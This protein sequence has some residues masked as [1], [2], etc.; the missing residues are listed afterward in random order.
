MGYFFRRERLLFIFCC[1]LLLV[2]SVACANQTS[3]AA[4]AVSTQTTVSGQ[5]TPA[6]ATSPA[7]NAS[8]PAS[9]KGRAAIMPAIPLGR[10]Q[11]IVYYRN[12]NG[13]ATLRE[14]DVQD[15]TSSIIASI[16]G[17]TIDSAQ[18]A[19]NG[20]WVLMVVQKNGVQALQL[21][22]VDGQDLQ[23]L[24]CAS[25]GQKV[26][27]QWSP[28]HQ[29]ILFSQNS[30]HEAKLLLLNVMSGV[31]QVEFSN[32]AYGQLKPLT[33]LDN[34][35]VYIGLVSSGLLYQP[36]NLIVLDT[37]KGANQQAS[38]LKTI[39]GSG[40]SPWSF[41]CGVDGRTA[42]FVTS[43]EPPRAGALQ[44]VIYAQSALSSGF[45]NA[46]FTSHS[47]YITAVRVV[48][49]KTLMFFAEDPEHTH[50]SANG[51]YT[52]G[53]DGHGLKQVVSAQ[54]PTLWPFN[55][56][57]QYT[58]SSFSRNGVYYVDGLSYGSFSGGSLTAYGS[59]QPDDTLVG[60]TT[61]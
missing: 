45:T 46:I 6:G 57:S 59:A 16:S 34:N 31:L 54:Q 43:I 58:W 32:A 53:T 13:S 8:C 38:D 37:S 12:T 2:G 40:D 19:G 26:E 1:L 17:E 52:I 41:D 44:S 25:A 48:S 11:E 7:V 20:Q 30:A 9:G 47:L 61:K 29:Q 24:Y 21:V 50:S 23:T 27:A 33:W 39:V 51:L 15:K 28:N 5:K 35:H 56:T 36:D 4:G 22:R 55:P 60:W 3:S 42:Y 14:F 10:R 18:L 49:A